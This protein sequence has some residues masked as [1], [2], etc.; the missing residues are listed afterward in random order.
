L[1]STWVGRDAL[2]VVRKPGFIYHYFNPV[3]VERWGLFLAVR[4]EKDRVYIGSKGARTTDPQ[5]WDTWNATAEHIKASERIQSAVRRVKLAWPLRPLGLVIAV[6]LG[7]AGFFV[8]P[9]VGLVAG[10]LAF[11]LLEWLADYLST[12]GY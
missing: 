10:L 9:A 6:I 11:V 8:H 12:H 5:R 7:I 4:Q 2:V 1:P 3:K